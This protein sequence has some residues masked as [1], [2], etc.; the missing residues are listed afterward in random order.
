[1]MR[2]RFRFSLIVFAIAAAV[3]AA[4]VLARN[5]SVPKP[6]LLTLSDNMKS[7][8]VG[9]TQS[10][11]IGLAQHDITATF[12][13]RRL[14]LVILGTQE[15][16]GTT[17]SMMLAHVDLDRRLATLISVPRDSWV[18]I[19][20][21]GFAKI[22]AAYAFGGAALAGRAVGTLLGT[23]VD[24]TIAV[25]PA[26][27]KQIVDAIGGLNVNVERDMDYDDN[28]GN[29]HIHLKH[30]EHYLNGGQVLEYI[31]FRHDAESDWG[32]MRRQ[33]QIIHEIEREVGEPQNWPKLPHLITL[34][35]KDVK[36]SLTDAQMEA[37]VE[38]YR[39]VPAE[40][41]RTLTVPG[42]AA[43][44]GDVSVVIVDDWWAKMIGQVVCSPNDP[45]PGVVLVANATGVPS[46]STIS[47]SA[48]RGGGWDVRSAVDEPAKVRSAIVGDAVTAQRLALTFTDFDRRPGRQTVLEF[49]TD[50]QPKI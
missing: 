5:H 46:V 14:N 45:P 33:Q 6:L 47:V 15:D 17:D 48:L 9:V 40:N 4:I 35:R 34:A 20:G 31:R 21:H 1:M 7:V 30:G 43:F 49:G 19:P 10:V 29:L 3:A 12:H 27:A 11:S 42:R 25:D 8:S 28:Y 38:L 24:A 16:E 41:V 37:L 18:A 36:T 22:N 13:K 23:H 26:G 50:V 39:G 44:V 32:R 2:R